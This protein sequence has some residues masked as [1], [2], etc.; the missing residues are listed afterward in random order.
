MVLQHKYGQLARLKAV[1]P[2]RDHRRS[3]WQAIHKKFGGIDPFV[4]PEMFKLINRESTESG[5]SRIVKENWYYPGSPSEKQN[6]LAYHLFLPRYNI[7]HIQSLQTVE[8]W[9]DGTC[10]NPVVGYHQVN[11]FFQTLFPL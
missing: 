2:I 9:F 3:C 4:V 8:V 11:I 10:F 6:S 1:R 5:Y 7:D